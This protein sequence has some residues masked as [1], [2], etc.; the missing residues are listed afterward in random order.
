MTG[1]KSFKVESAE[2]KM[3]VQLGGPTKM[4]EHVFKQV[5]QLFTSFSDYWNVTTASL[6]VNSTVNGTEANMT[7]NLTPQFGYTKNP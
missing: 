7:V 3:T 5:K 1:G 6:S 2:I 4:Y